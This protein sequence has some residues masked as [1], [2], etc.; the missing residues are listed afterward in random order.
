MRG[1]I[2]RRLAKIEAATGGAS[3]VVVFAGEPIPPHAAK[4][5]IVVPKRAVFERTKNE[6]AASL[7]D[8][9]SVNLHPT[10]L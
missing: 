1:D 8:G 9:D 10:H 2:E 3:H 5:V 7:S 6:V 4:L